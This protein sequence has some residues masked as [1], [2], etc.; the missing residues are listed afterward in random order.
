MEHRLPNQAQIDAS[1]AI[2]S[3]A[4][5]ETEPYE[6]E[7]L[8]E[9]FTVLPC[10]F[11]PKYFDSTVIFSEIFPYR[12]EDTFCEIGCGTGVTSVFAARNGSKRVLAVDIN[13][14]AVENTRLNARLHGLDDRIECR[15]SNVFS[16]V[17][18]SESFDTIYWNLPFIYVRTDFFFRGIGERAL[19]DPGYQTIRRF[20][21][22]APAHLKSQGRIIAG[23][24]D[25][26]DENALES[27][28]ASADVTL[29]RIGGK[30][31][32]EGGEVEFR[33]YEAIPVYH[34]GQ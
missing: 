20:F 9:R 13:P 23:F 5:S 15:V 26:G 25:F 28:C 14:R 18:S 3:N 34:A 22:E 11:S 7:I 16:N 24:G 4:E 19:F 32:V 12:V 2:L 33:L 31:G 29:R 10:V 17:A 6:V 27:I 21:M 30:E 1:R 8:G